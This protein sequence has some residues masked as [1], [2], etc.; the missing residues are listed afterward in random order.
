MVVQ[1]DPGV[2]AWTWK[3]PQLVPWYQNTNWGLAALVRLIQPASESI[4][5]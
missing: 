5:C 1:A 2:H 3:S 4:G